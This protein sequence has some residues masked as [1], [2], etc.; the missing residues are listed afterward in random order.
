MT[1]HASRFTRETGTFRIEAAIDEAEKQRRAA[2]ADGA[3]HILRAFF[4]GDNAQPARRVESGFRL[5]KSFQRPA[6]QQ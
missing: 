1:S 3:H 2:Q 5:T 6:T 4:F